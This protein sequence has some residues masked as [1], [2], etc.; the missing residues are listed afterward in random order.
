MRFRSSVSRLPLARYITL[1]STLAVA[2]GE[3]VR[4]AAGTSGAVDAPRLL[5]D[6][7]PGAWLTVGRNWRADRFSPLAR[8]HD[9][10]VDSLGVAWEFDFR[11]RRGRVER[12]LEATPVIVDGVVYQ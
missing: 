4:Q 10:N 8:I 2:C 6:D 3:P 5:R 7:E 12:G 9:G 1:A 11:S